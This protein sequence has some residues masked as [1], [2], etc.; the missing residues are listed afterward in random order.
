MDRNID[1]TPTGLMQQRL[2][3]RLSCISAGDLL[4]QLGRDALGHLG[5]R[6]HP[7]QRKIASSSSGAIGASTCSTKAL[8]TS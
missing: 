1:A 8:T 5:G 4:D 2:L 6:H 7:P 3:H